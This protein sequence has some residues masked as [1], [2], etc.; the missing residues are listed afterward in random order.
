[1][2][3]RKVMGAAF[4]AAAWAAVLGTAAAVVVAPVAVAEEK[5][6]PEKLS[7]AV[8]KPLQ[9]AQELAGE[10]KFREALAKVREAEKIGEKTPYEAFVINQM[11]AYVLAGAGD[12]GGAAKAYEAQIASGR[13]PAAEMGKALKNTT[14]LFYQVENYGKAAQ[15][16]NRY[17]TEVGPDAEI[18]LLVAQSYF[19]TKDYA[20]TVKHISAAISTAERGGG[21]PDENWIR[22]LHASKEGLND[23][24]GANEALEKLVQLYPKPDYW[25][26]LLAGLLSGGGINDRLLLEVFR[27]KS[28][29]GLL[30][31]ADDYVEMAQV[32][33]L[34]GLPGEAQSVLEK[35]FAAKKLGGDQRHQGLLSHAKGLAASD[36]ASLGQQE[37][38]AS[39]APKGEAL[40][41]LGEAYASYGQYD[42]AI[43]AI[44]RGIKKGGVDNLTDAR[45][46]LGRALVAAGRVQEGRATFK[47]VETKGPLGKVARLWVIHSNR[48]SGA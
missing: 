33:L 25:N 20:N 27:L 16:G 3:F 21:R 6:K 10:G 19:V 38:Q 14:R 45:I 26:D 7:Q 35:G 11:L 40:V 30:R 8:G 37:G 44:E 47:L 22:I 48:S 9:A 18:Q 23:R 13:L 28:A 17:L 41:R 24:A 46:Q 36:K 2:K 39:A 29:T 31:D 42:K 43:S 15:Y 4:G 1:M 32:A 12:F 34:L 5:K